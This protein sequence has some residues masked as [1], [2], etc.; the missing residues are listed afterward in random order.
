MSNFHY[1][2]GQW[3]LD[4]ERQDLL[5]RWN[6]PDDP[7]EVS[8]KSN[9]KYRFLCPRH[10]HEDTEYNL[11][12]IAEGKNKTV[13]CKKCNSFG[14]YVIDKFGE[15][16]LEKIWSDKNI[17]SPF[18]VFY[19]SNKKFWFV[20]QNNPKHIYD[21][22]LS[23]V[24]S[25]VG[26]PYCSHQ[27]IMPEESLGAVY[28]KSLDVWSEKNIKTPFDYAPFSTVKV[29]WKCEKGIHDDYF[30]T[31]ASSQPKDYECPICSVERHCLE[32]KED[33]YGNVYGELTVLYLDVLETKKRQ[34][35]VWIC[36]CSCGKIVT[37]ELCKLKSG[38]TRT[39]GD[40]TIHYSGENNKNY[41]GGITPEL[42][43]ARNNSFYD[44]WRD[45]VYAKD[46][47]TCQCCGKSKNIDKEAH[48]FYGF[49][50]NINRRYDVS[51]GILLCKQC[52]SAVV[53]GGFHYIYGT[54]KNTP[55]QLEEYINN[56]RKL[57]GIDVPFSYQ[58]YLNGNMIK[59]NELSIKDDLK[60][61]N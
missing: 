60:G 23:H 61:G 26:C 31:I 10:L 5:D 34:K 38:N 39:C 44:K 17:I 6:S 57:L 53:E 45:E 7:F 3:C 50:D 1:S 35:A 22:T 15:E 18:D 11:F 54:N 33:V 41:K 43:L 21:M 46:W 32:R 16:H 58:E 56:K 59:P 30:R 55:Q 37:V 2:F 8:F 52:H 49:S 14:Q 9:N 25:G 24:S 42:I 20:C 51:N 40:R 47:Y 13:K 36:K 27:R 12:D 29:W 48:H 19:G 28:P 4:N